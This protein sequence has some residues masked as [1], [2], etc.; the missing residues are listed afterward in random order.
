VTYYTSA[1]NYTWTDINGFIGLSGFENVRGTDQGDLIIGDSNA[2]ILDGGVGND[3]ITGGGGTDTIIGGLGSDAINLTETTPVT[4]TVRIAAGDSLATVAGYDLVTAFK[5]FDGI[6]STTGVD[7]L[8]LAS[9]AIATD[10]AAVDGAN[11]VSGNIKSHSITS[12]LISFGGTD[13]YTAA[14]PLT[15]TAANLADVFGYLQA[16]IT[17]TDTV[18]FVSG[19]NTFVFQDG[20]TAAD[21]LVELVGVADTTGVSTSEF[22]AHS[23]WIG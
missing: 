8:D 16:N 10:A 15:I 2:N 18:A 1:N 14:P 6:L 20:G 11:S 22:N 4:D 19:G 5:S 12:G 13:V 23:I 21:T 7:Q 9:I 17:G 3:N